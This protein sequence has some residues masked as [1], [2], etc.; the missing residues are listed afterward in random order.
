MPF[1]LARILR[2]TGFSFG[3]ILV[4]FYAKKKKIVF[5]FISEIYSNWECTSNFFSFFTSGGDFAE[6]LSGENFLNNSKYNVDQT[7]QAFTII[8][9]GF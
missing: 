2:C 7:R 1:I 4:Y 5:L 9:V 3:E 6:T 8:I